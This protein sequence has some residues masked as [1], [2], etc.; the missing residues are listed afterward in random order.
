MILRVLN[1]KLTDNEHNARAIPTRFY[2]SNRVNANIF[3]NT[4]KVHIQHTHKDHSFK[5]KNNGVLNYTYI[6]IKMYLFSFRL[7]KFN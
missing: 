1:L 4:F 7:P 3:T 5:I 6:D 2:S